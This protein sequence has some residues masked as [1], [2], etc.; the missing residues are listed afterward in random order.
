MSITQV[1]STSHSRLN[2]FENCLIQSSTLI[3]LWVIQLVRY[4]LLEGLGLVVTLPLNCSPCCKHPEFFA[5]IQGGVMAKSNLSMIWNWY[6][7]E[8][9]I[10][11]TSPCLR[12]L[13]HTNAFIDYDDNYYEWLTDMI[14]V[15]CLILLRIGYASCWSW[16]RSHLL[17]CWRSL[18]QWPSILCYY[19]FAV[20]SRRGKFKG[21]S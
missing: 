6:M 2:F 12:I 15:Y 13:Y 5:R 10:Q 8:G 3:E 18:F 16:W 11:W 20:S 21:L 14:K 4:C 19:R 9:M 7:N 1:E 17:S